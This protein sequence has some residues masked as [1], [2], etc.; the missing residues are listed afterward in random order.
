MYIKA[1]TVI[2]VI[3]LTTFYVLFST[4]LY[5][6]D[7]LLHVCS[8]LNGQTNIPPRVGPNAKE[9]LLMA[10]EQFNQF[11][12]ELSNQS[13]PKGLPFTASIHVSSGP[14][15]V[16]DLHYGFNRIGPVYY[17]QHSYFEHKHL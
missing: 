1:L 17:H 11:N 14:N 16:I 4:K 8:F 15:K 7:Q 10:K 9:H 13:F 12:C 5:T 3:L 6:K 2:T